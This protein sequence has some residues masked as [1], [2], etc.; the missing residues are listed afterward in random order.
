MAERKASIPLHH[1]ERCNSSDPIQVIVTPSDPVPPL[2]RRVTR[3]ASS[4]RDRIWINLDHAQK[5][6]GTASC[7]PGL[8][9]QHRLEAVPTTFAVSLSPLG[10]SRA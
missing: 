10:R 2:G 9:P 1:F 3:P 4:Q 7:G 6:I 5:G 8:L